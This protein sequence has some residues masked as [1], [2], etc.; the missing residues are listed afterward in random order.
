[1]STSTPNIGA[2]IAHSLAVAQIERTEERDGYRQLPLD[3]IE[4]TAHSPNTEPV[5]ASVFRFIMHTQSSCRSLSGYCLE[6]LSLV[7]SEVGPS[8][9]LLPLPAILI[10]PYFLLLIYKQFLFTACCLLFAVFCWAKEIPCLHL[11]R[12]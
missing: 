5:C 6:I 11:G 12:I 7:L 10:S 4:E 2:N 3:D 1:M 8:I 9:C